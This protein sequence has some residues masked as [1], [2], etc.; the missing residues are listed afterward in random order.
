MTSLKGGENI[1]L[2][3]ARKLK[4]FSQGQLAEA[5]GVSRVTVARLERGKYSPNMK[6]LARIANAL[7][8]PVTELIEK[9][10]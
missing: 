5:A 8:V 9:A 4:G 1:K 6:T 3:V 7:G 2:A 10:G